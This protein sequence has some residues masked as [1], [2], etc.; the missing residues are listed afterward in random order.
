MP[1][2]RHIALATQDPIKTAEF[3]KKMFGFREVGRAGTGA[4]ISAT[5]RSIS[6]C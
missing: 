4:S 2:L 5:A 6:R 1:K 3:Y